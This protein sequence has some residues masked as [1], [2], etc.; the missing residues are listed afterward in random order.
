MNFEKNEEIH[1]EHLASKH[2]NISDV[3]L[4]TDFEGV[5]DVV[6]EMFYKNIKAYF[7]YI[8]PERKGTHYPG[9]KAEIKVIGVEYN[10]KYFLED[11][12]DPRVI[13]WI[14]NHLWNNRPEKHKGLP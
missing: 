1:E 14:K 3:F 9:A 10:D 2:T 5:D 12:L 11:D 13:K 7:H 4:N 6:D 8:P